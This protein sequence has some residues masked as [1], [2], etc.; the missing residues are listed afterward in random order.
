MLKSSSTK[1]AELKNGEVGAGDGRKNR[2][3]PIGKHELDNIN[4]DGGCS[5]N[6]D[7]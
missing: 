2:A 5:G 3:E 1:S 6:F 4:D 7:R